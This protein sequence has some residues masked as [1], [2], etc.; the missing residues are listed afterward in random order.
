M[1][2][3]LEAAVLTGEDGAEAWRDRMGALRETFLDAIEREGAL[4]PGWTVDSA[5]DWV[6]ARVQPAT[7]RHLVVDRGWDPGDLAARTVASVRE[8]ILA[9]V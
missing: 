7:W 4:R 6:W 9:N 1:A 8:E 5:A 2:Q 3:A